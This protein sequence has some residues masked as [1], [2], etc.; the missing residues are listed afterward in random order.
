MAVLR[1]TQQIPTVRIDNCAHFA[2][3]LLDN[4]KVVNNWPL[5][6]TAARMLIKSESCT[7]LKLMYRT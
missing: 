6:I 5:L 1:H 2:Q 3:L 7:V 4:R